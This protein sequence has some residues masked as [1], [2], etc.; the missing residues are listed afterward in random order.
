MTVAETRRELSRRGFKVGHQCLKN[1][2]QQLDSEEEPATAQRPS[3]EQKAIAP[4]SG[5]DDTRLQSLRCSP[6]AC[7]QEPLKHRGLVTESHDRK[8]A[9]DSVYIGSPENTVLS[10]RRFSIWDADVVREVLHLRRVRNMTISETKQE[11]WT[12]GFQIDDQCLWNKLQQLD[13]VERPARVR[14]PRRRQKAMLSKMERTRRRNASILNDS[15]MSTELCPPLA[16]TQ[17]PLKQSCLPTESR[18]SEHALVAADSGTSDS[19][20]LR[21]VISLLTVELD[22]PITPLPAP[23]SRSRSESDLN[24]LEKT[25]LDEL[26]DSEEVTVMDGDPSYDDDGDM[27]SFSCVCRSPASTQRRDDCGIAA[28]YA[29]AEGETSSTLPDSLDC[30][31]QNDLEK[32]LLDELSECD[33][34]SDA[35]DN[36]DPEALS[37]DAGRVEPGAYDHHDASTSMP[38]TALMRLGE[39]VANASPNSSS[40]IE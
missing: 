5:T 7:T 29:S 34:M 28:S 32:A 36:S 22:R 15:S 4:E 9:S 39:D 16:S 13:A 12:R 6:P 3:S 2:L 11:L 10:D 17:E 1:K 14:R 19:T 25:L 33:E 18:V 30:S 31:A 20:M 8:R 35:G 21:L 37:V 23:V 40:V 38:G 24:D 26:S 27:P